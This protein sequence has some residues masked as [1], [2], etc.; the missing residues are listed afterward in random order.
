MG[1]VHLGVVVSALQA[2][3]LYEIKGNYGA[4]RRI[5]RRPVIAMER[6]RYRIHLTIHLGNGRPRKSRGL[7]GRGSTGRGDRDA[8][9]GLCPPG[10]AAGVER[11]HELR[12]R[13]RS[14]I[15]AL[16]PA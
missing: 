11:A 8:P 3:T 12:L 10:L 2:D 16:Q 9:W 5:F 1:R 13:T 15:E 6:V 7:R 14:V 4:V